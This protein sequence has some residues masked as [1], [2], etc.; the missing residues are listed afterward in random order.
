MFL[1][2]PFWIQFGKVEMKLN[3]AQVAES[4]VYVHTNPRYFLFMK[5]EIKYRNTLF[6]QY[7]NY[8]QTMQMTAGAGVRCLT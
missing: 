6:L 2:G 7:G 5:K 8:L 3:T 1:K 4:T